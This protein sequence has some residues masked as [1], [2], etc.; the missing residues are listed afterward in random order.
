MYRS[1]ARRSTHIVA[2]SVAAV[3]MSAAP[4]LAAPLDRDHFVEVETYTDTVCGEEWDVETTTEGQFMIKAGRA[5]DPTPYYFDNASERSVYTDPDD[6]DRG[7]VT[8]SSSVFKDVRITLISGTTYVFETMRVGTSALET[9]GRR[10]VAHDQGQQLW[11]FTVDT[12]G[13][14]D[15][16]AYELLDESL[17]RTTGHH[18]LAEADEAAYCDLVAEAVA[19]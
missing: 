18:S 10:A 16:D 17:I 8:T 6:A 7:F 4:T 13:G 1:R 12:K 9:L 5:G 2:L 3:A 15:L 19:G 14:S 11:A